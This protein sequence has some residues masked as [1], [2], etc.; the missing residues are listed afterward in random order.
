VVFPPDTD[1]PGFAEELKTKVRIEIGVASDKVCSPQPKETKLISDTAGLFQPSYVAKKMIKDSIVSL[2][3][4]EHLISL[5]RNINSTERKILVLHGSGWL[6]ACL[7]DLWY[8]SS[9]LNNGGY[10]ASKLHCSNDIPA[11]DFFFFISRCF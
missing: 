9:C 2:S 4:H 3:F 7:S 10:P 6:H 1:T 11:L 8:G 5:I